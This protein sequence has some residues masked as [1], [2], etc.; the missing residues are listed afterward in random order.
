M[1]PA[2]RFGRRI[3]VFILLYLILTGRCLGEDERIVRITI[4][5]N[6][7]V[8]EDVTRRTSPSQF[9]GSKRISNPSM[10]R[11]FLPT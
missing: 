2:L 9:R 11:A 7:K 10:R 5:G 4:L 3:V 8:A 1:D 6:E